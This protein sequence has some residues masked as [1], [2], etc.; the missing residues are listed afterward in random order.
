MCILL[1]FNKSEILSFK[2]IAEATNIPV[3]DL[4]RNLL[5]LSCG[6]LKVLLK[7][8]KTLR[9]DPADR[10]AYNKFFK[11][12]LLKVKIV[13]VQPS[14]NN[15]NNGDPNQDDPNGIRSKIDEDRKHQYPFLLLYN[16]P[17]FYS[18]I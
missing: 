2:E 13:S 6:K 12:K 18:I 8:T 5:S 3:E 15:N 14:S 1:L 11:S 4:K 7:E 10:F 9:I 16:L 17:F